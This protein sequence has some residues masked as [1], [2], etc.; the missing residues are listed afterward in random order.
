MNFHLLNVRCV[1]GAGLN[2]MDTF[3]HLILTTVLESGHYYPIL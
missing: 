3:P 1:L 2:A